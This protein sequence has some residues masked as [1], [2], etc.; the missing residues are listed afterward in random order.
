MLILQI[1]GGIIL[2]VLILAYWPYIIASSVILFV[3]GLVCV[4]VAWLVL[5]HTQ[6]ELIAWS[7][8]VVIYSGLGIAY[9]LWDKRRRQKKVATKK[10]P[11][12]LSV[13][14]QQDDAERKT[15]DE[16]V[17]AYE[18]FKNAPIKA[19]DKIKSLFRKAKN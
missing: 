3:V 18:N 13:R 10:A 5:G 12:V 19:I 1:A 16:A 7:S 4:G 14:L 17:A 11:E 6:E 8:V 15:E 9:Y 2:A